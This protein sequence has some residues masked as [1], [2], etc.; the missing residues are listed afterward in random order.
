MAEYAEYTDRELVA[1]LKSGDQAAFTEIYDRYWSPMYIHVYKM[2]RSRDD[3]MDVLQDMFSALWLKAADINPETK[4]SG[5]LYLSARN[6]VFN[7][8]QQNKV[9]ND[10]LGS[11]AAYMTEAGTETMDALDQRDMA[12]AVEAEIANLPP[13]MREVFELSRKHNLTHK[14]IAEHLNISEQTVR[15]QV[16][17]ALRIL[18]PKLHAIGAGIAILIFIH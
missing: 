8:I 7:F 9:K 1:Q 3:A 17:N 6:R 11:V 16:Q 13:R 4:L 10:Y 2:L 14:E 12:E 5:H 15:K 18:K